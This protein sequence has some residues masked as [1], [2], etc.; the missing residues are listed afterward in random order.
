MICLSFALFASGPEV[1]ASWMQANQQ[2]C[3][4]LLSSRT[5]SPC[6]LIKVG[7]LKKPTCA[8]LCS[9]DHLE[10]LLQPAI[11]QITMFAFY[12]YGNALIII[13]VHQYGGRDKRAWS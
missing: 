9:C 12:L 13:M 4:F 11:A 10:M 8:S 1:N 2:D 5:C 7:S 3:H 6:C